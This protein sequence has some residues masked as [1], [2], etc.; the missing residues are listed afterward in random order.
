MALGQVQFEQLSQP[1]KQA[2]ITDNITIERSN[3]ALALKE[4]PKQQRI[5]TLQ[6]G[7]ALTDAEQLHANQQ[8][9]N[10]A[11]DIR[12]QAAPDAERARASA[13]K[14]TANVAA[15]MRALQGLS[16]YDAGTMTPGALANASATLRSNNLLG[17]D[18]NLFSTPA[19][20]VIRNKDGSPDIPIANLQ[21]GLIA[22]QQKATGDKTTYK[23]TNFVTPDG[24]SVPT[25][26]I[27]SN[28]PMSQAQ[29]N[30]ASNIN[31][32]ASGNTDVLGALD[33]LL[34]DV[35]SLGVVAPASQQGS[36]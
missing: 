10:T 11:R 15:G 24:V 28:N 13:A 33:T 1:Q 5:K 32:P 30:Q 35:S 12:A 17:E 2:V 6:L 14:W 22:T 8:Y 27:T 23:Y 36:N 21:R 25:T 20:V 34:G 19:G 29:V 7:M 9:V 16:I 18:Q 31:T 26:T 3:T 4:L